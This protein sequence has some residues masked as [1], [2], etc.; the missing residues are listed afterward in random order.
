MQAP[1][2]NSS[3]NSPVAYAGTWFKLILQKQETGNYCTSEPTTNCTAPVATAAVSLLP[4]LPLLLLLLQA[5]NLKLI[6]QKQETGNYCASEPTTNSTAPVATAAGGWYQFSVPTSAFKC[7]GGGI[8]LSD[9][10]Q[11][12][13][14]NK[15]ERNV[16]VCI[17]EI[18]IVR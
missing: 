4:L 11:F 17:G 8:T 3:L 12:E 1:G 10:T 2:L 6:L 18:K 15:S 13:F 9:V 5:P 7:G 14:Q 16:D